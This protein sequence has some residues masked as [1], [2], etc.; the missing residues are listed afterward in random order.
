MTLKLSILG[1]VDLFSGELKDSI[2]ISRVH[3]GVSTYAG[4][5][6]KGIVFTSFM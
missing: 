4:Y 5:T 6:G 1:S 2:A 3:K